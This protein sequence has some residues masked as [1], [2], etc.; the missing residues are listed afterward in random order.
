[1]CNCVCVRWVRCWWSSIQTERQWDAP[2]ICPHTHCIHTGAQSARAHTY[3]YTHSRA[4]KIP[5][6]TCFSL[7]V[8]TWATTSI[9]LKSIRTHL[10][11]L[12]RQ[13]RVDMFY[14]INFISLLI[15][16]KRTY[17]SEEWQTFRCRIQTK[18]LIA[19]L[20]R[21][22]WSDWSALL[23]KPT[24]NK[25]AVCITQLTCQIIPHSRTCRQHRSRIKWLT[26][27]IRN[28]V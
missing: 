20:A 14:L 6:M 1:M 16:L 13:R 27:V 9:L 18:L 26:H 19:G 8:I 10:V 4:L 22:K 21:V 3:T 15:K 2:W 11:A 24:E 25:P 7:T 12:Y 23:I 28:S 17:I 5:F